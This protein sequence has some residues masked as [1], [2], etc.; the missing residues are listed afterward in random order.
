MEQCETSIRQGFLGTEMENGKGTDDFGLCIDS[1][2]QNRIFHSR[3][4]RL[5]LGKVRL[6]RVVQRIE[7]LRHSLRRI[8]KRKRHGFHYGK[9][10]IEISQK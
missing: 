2:E 1:A 8:R 3:S 5:F 4:T 6:R 9:Y 10:R 7:K